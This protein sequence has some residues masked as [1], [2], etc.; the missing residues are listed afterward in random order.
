MAYDLFISYARKDNEGGWVSAFV[1]ALL[2]SHRRFSG[3]ELEVFFD[4]SEIRDGDDWRWR[5]LQALRE[6]WLMVA[7]LSPNYQASTH[8]RMEWDTYASHELDRFV[9]GEGITPVYTVEIPGSGGDASADEWLRQASARNFLDA[10]GW[11][12]EGPQALQ[13]L[14][15]ARRLEEL[16]RQ[17]DERRDREEKAKAS[18]TNL[19][20]YNKRFVG[21]VE[22]LRQVRE[23]LGLGSVGVVA[24]LHGMG[25]VGKTELALAYAHAF[26]WAYPAGRYLVRC[27]RQ[28]DLRLALLASL[29]EPLGIEL[30]EEQKRDPVLAYER[31]R[32][33]LET[34]EQVLLVLDNV[35]REELLS[36]E[37]AQWLPD[38]RRVQVLATTRLPLDA[39]PDLRVFTLDVLPEADAVKL[40]GSYRPLGEGETDF[41]RD[42]ARRLGCHTLAVEVV[43]VYLGQHAGVPLADYL[44]R[45]D[46]E[47]LGAV[48]AAGAEARIRHPEAVLSKLLASTLDL[49]TPLEMLALRFA[50]LL[51][52]DFVPPV[53]L[54]FLVSDQ[55][56]EAAEGP[57]P[58]HPDVWEDALK[59]LDGLR[60]LIRPQDGRLARMHQL[61]QQVV[62][63]DDDGRPERQAAIV[64]HARSRC[65]FLDEGWLDWENRWEIEPLGALAGHLMERGVDGGTW[66]ANSVGLQL[67]G[68][69]R[70]AEAEPLMQRALEIDEASYGPD[71]PEVARDLNNL[72]ML[73][74]ATNRLG[75]AEPLMR[76]AL[77][78]AEA[79]YGPDHPDVATDLNNLASLL[80]ATNRLSEAEPLIRRALA[81]AE[82]SYGPDHPDVARDLNNLA[83]LLQAT[84][85]LAEAEPLMRRALAIDEKSYGPDHP[86]VARDLNNLALLLYA[87]KRHL[88]AE[89]LFRRA[90]AIDEA[91]YGPDHPDVARDLNNLAAL[92]Y[93]TNRPSEA[94][95][96]FRR[97]LAIDE[98]SYG[99]DHPDVARHLNNLAELL[100]AT[101]CLAEA[102][103]LFRR[104]LA[105]YE[106]SWGPDHPEVATG[107]NNLAELLRATNRLSEA[108]PLGRRA[109]EILLK[110]TRA[111][112]H[113]HPHLELVASNYAALLVE[114]GVPRDDAVERVKK[115]LGD[116]GVKI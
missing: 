44:K 17:I 82:A 5:I 97:A 76:R 77:A 52:P 18:R 105:I 99:P 75:E 39:G 60:L 50:A 64:E 40:V 43:G 35:D 101:N 47:G 57:A 30:T 115:L 28:S 86:D 25:G 84:N 108:E 93:A 80:Y 61:V 111:T 33:T 49:L 113:P 102:E 69:A 74:Q 54:R 2:E 23:S 3:R 78:I 104:A 21:R 88:E 85:R 20:A 89:P 10:R 34:G 110:F 71:H 67:H 65:Q 90:L 11:Y 42:I 66:I 41:A 62:T 16:S 6:S 59:R 8:C 37:Q 109:L 27:E 4:K 103:P 106:Q 87:T 73:L 48:D 98:A 9:V 13:R 92:L 24:T 83:Q 12:P 51:P 1:E 116:Y 94:E 26:A 46:A 112:G 58:G 81:I 14:D 22:E 29:V 114:M 36:P 31:L 79:S 7:F 19:P 72:A 55:F 107:L 91:S 15:I 100:K 32:R 38:K 70:Y 95:L 53:W 68:L 96:L 45:M 56:P 63:A